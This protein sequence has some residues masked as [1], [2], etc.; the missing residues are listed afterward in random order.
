L[1]HR[2][3]AHKFIAKNGMVFKRDGLMMP[4]NFHGGPLNGWRIR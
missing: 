2:Q 3:Q 4:E 1:I